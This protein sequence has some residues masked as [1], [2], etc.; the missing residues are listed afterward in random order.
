MFNSYKIP[1]TILL[2]KKDSHNAIE[3]DVTFREILEGAEY[4]KGK[5][6]S[7]LTIV[8]GRDA[9]GNDI[10]SD[11][12]MMPHLLIAGT[13]GSGKSVFLNNVILSILFEAT[14]EEV[15]FIILDPKM[16]EFNAYESIAH[17][18]IPIITDAKLSVAALKSSVQE[19]I[20]RCNAF[21][22]VGAKDLLQYN[23]SVRKN[24]RST[25]PYLVIIIDELSILTQVSEETE[26]CIQYIT[27]MGRTVGVH[28]VIA[29]QLP[30]LVSNSIKSNI[31]SRISLRVVSK[32]ESHFILGQSGA[33]KL[34]AS[35][36]MLFLSYGAH[37]PTRVHIPLVSD[38]EIRAVSFFARRR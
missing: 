4:T 7:K 5:K 38:F 21:A 15:Q 32:E 18:R 28:M 17:L 22:K 35:G 25:M 13:T 16:I 34:T 3:Q 14:P 2:S 24:K 10:I 19:I 12:A 29:T 37:T 20:R 36:D 26:E 8:L 6:Q 30:R 11:L 27:Q 23:D 9:N 33:E 31:P 1:D